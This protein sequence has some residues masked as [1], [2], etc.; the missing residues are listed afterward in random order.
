M[1]LALNQASNTHTLRLSLAP[2]RHEYRL[3]VDGHWIAD[4]Y[5]TDWVLNE[6]GDPHSIVEVPRTAAAIRETDLPCGA[7]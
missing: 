5:N 6:F 3:V 2:G 1:D 4:P 7:D